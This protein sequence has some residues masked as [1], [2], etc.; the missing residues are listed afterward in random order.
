MLNRSTV[1]R[2]HE[3]GE[4]RATRR[5]MQRC[6]SLRE[7][8]CMARTT[9]IAARWP[10]CKH[11]YRAREQCR[12]C[13]RTQ[14]GDEYGES[15]DNESRF[16]HRS[17]SSSMC[18]VERPCVSGY[19]LN[20]VIGL[21]PTRH[22]SVNSSCVVYVGIFHQDAFQRA[23]PRFHDLARAPHGAV[24]VS[25]EFRRSPSGYARS[26]HPRGVHRRRPLGPR[27]G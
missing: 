15:I 5:A 25:S 8:F 14:P 11:R 2:T 7:G 23:S 16:R 18:S 20:A 26:S 4:W 22:P 27:S 3:T 6:V 1:E 17:L 9:A 13:C 19:C 12:L 24:R 21:L 10:E